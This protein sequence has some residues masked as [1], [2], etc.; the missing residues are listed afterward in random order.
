MF[1][2]PS[3]ALISRSCCDNVPVVEAGRCAGSLSDFDLSDFPE[4]K[5]GLLLTEKER[6]APSAPAFARAAAVNRGS[7]K[8]L[9]HSPFG[10]LCNTFILSGD[11]QH[12]AFGVGGTDQICV[13]ASLPGAL[14]PIQG[15]VSELGCHPM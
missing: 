5:G 6:K 4:P 9:V 14:A 11:L 7:E 8:S 10:A 2:L 1:Q 12:R 13:D 3:I 15:I